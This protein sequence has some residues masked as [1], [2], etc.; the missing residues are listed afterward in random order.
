MTLA[1]PAH[2]APQGASNST[3]P[4]GAKS[5]DA[6]I[7]GDKHPGDVTL[8]APREFEV[9]ADAERAKSDTAHDR[10][11]GLEAGLLKRLRA[12]QYTTD[13]AVQSA[14]HAWMGYEG[15][16]LV[17]SGQSG[18]PG[19]YFPQTMRLMDELDGYMYGRTF[20]KAA[21]HREKGELFGINHDHENDAKEREM[22]VQL[23]TPLRDTIYERRI[24]A[25]VCLAE[26]R[27]AMGDKQRAEAGFLNA[28]GFDW[29]QVSDPVA[30]HALKDLYVRAGLGLIQCRRGNLAALRDTYFL[31]AASRELGPA[32]KAAIDEAR[33]QAPPGK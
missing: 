26:D 24:E 17:E 25:I 14:V 29:T 27:Y 19:A 13:D 32:L 16:R 5:S 3:R 21:I 10:P 15:R 7:A 2:A 28:L 4:D 20:L 11:V 33:D 18:R 1:V 23:L 9:W 8:M 31:G 22:V 30:L 12:G 6:S